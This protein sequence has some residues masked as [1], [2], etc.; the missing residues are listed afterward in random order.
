MNAKMIGVTLFVLAVYA[1]YDE[2][3]EEDGAVL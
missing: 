2:G 3:F 1:V